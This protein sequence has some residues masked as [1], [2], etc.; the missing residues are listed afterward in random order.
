MM[1]KLWMEVID[2]DY[3]MVNRMTRIYYGD[4]F[5]LPLITVNAFVNLGLIDD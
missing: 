4:N 5:H 1:I 3:K 2:N